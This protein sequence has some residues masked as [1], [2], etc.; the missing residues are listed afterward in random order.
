MTRECFEVSVDGKVGHIKLSRPKQLNAMSLAF[1]RELPEIVRELDARG[2]VRAVVISSTGKHFTA[3]MDLSVFEGSSSLDT[4]SVRARE[5]F[6]QK[7]EE[8]QQSF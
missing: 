8:L 6:R 2:D 4:D 1:W 7:L 5:R 3:G